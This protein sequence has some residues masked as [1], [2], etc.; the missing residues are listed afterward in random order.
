MMIYSRNG[1]SQPLYLLHGMIN[2]QK[3]QTQTIVGLNSSIPFHVEKDAF[4]S[5]KK[6][7]AD[8]LSGG[9]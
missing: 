8:G 9:G 2:A 7:A 3:Y 1:R 6:C 4:L 5:P